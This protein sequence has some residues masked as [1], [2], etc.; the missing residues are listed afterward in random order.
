MFHFAVYSPSQQVQFILG[1]EME[2][3]FDAL[4]EECPQIFT[5]M[6]ELHQ[7]EEGGMLWKETAR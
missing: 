1:N 3:K 6:E 7:D 4:E 2:Q 5:E